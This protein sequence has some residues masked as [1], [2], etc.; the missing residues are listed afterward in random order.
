MASKRLR[1][2]SALVASALALSL[3]SHIPAAFADD[4]NQL[5]RCYEELAVLSESPLR[6]LDRYPRYLLQRHQASQGSDLSEDLA[7]CESQL[8]VL[9]AENRQLNP[10]L[11]SRL[12]NQSERVPRGY[13]DLQ[14]YMMGIPSLQCESQWF[15]ALTP[16]QWQQLQPQLARINA[17]EYDCTLAL[18]SLARG[19]RLR[20]QLA[21]TTQRLI[22]LS[23]R[24]FTP[25]WNSTLNSLPAE[26]ALALTERES[27]LDQ[28]ERLLTDQLAVIHVE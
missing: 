11:L 26:V 1:K 4:T 14:T 2:H 10:G 8:S 16:A 6:T 24:V 19:G 23:R 21:Q 12:C 7:R 27:Q 13:D 3:L 20:E 22:S 15:D 25:R 28:C 18:E 9:V 17:L 5:E